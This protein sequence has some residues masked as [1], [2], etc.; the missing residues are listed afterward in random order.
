MKKFLCAII[1]AV[2]FLGLI[3]LTAC[4]GVK[5]MGKK[6]EDY[7]IVYAKYEAEDLMKKNL[8]LASLTEWDFN[9]ITAE[10]LRD[11]IKAEFGVELPIVKDTESEK[12]GN[13]ILIGNTNRLKYA[14]DLGLDF[15]KDITLNSS[16]VNTRYNYS[17][18][19]P[20][21][22]AIGVKDKD[23][24]A[25]GGCYGTTYFASNQLFEEFKKNF[26]G[27]NI[28]LSNNFKVE[29]TKDLEVI[30]CI[31]D[32]ITQGY[33]STSAD[34][35]LANSYCY[36][37]YPSYLQRLNWKTSYVY[38]FGRSAMTMLSTTSNSYQDSARWTKAI[39]MREVLDKVII[40]L[41]TNDSKIV[42]VN[43]NRAWTTNDD[44]QFIA[45]FFT[46]VDTLSENNKN[47]QFILSN[48]PVTGSANPYGADFI[49]ELQQECVIKAKQKGYDIE[50]CDMNTYSK[51]NMPLNTC[52]DS[53][54]LH[55]NSKGY[56]KMAVAL[57]GA[58]KQFFN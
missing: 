55:P 17:T 44:N 49:L 33:K 41:G 35:G 54:K 12:T 43:E 40:A 46:L 50:L 39:E 8:S 13:E 2:L 19:D 31:G 9:K 18:T 42:L 57:N 11:K 26:D 15:V 51:E 10:E 16:G 21:K 36:F 29:G 6:L 37:A 7:T 47:I 25:V 4:G 20:F 45:D 22:Y 1:S 34:T 52:F 27:K 32:S 53:D 56:Y 5:I 24:Y 30:G 28:N 38:N 58:I 48:C 14:D 3:P 23:F